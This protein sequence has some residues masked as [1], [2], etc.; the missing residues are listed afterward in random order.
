MLFLVSGSS[1]AGKT[2][3]LN[4]LRGRLSGLAMHDFDE[5]EIPPEVDTAWRQQANE[6]W[7]R[8]GLEYEAEGSDL[9]LAGQTPFGELLATPSA[10]KLQAISACLLDC[11]APTQIQRLA[12]R[13]QDWLTDSG[14]ELQDF[15]NWAAWHRRHAIDPSWMLHV[16]RQP[17]S[18]PDLQWKRWTDWHAGDPRWRVRV[19]DT[20]PLSID[21]VGDEL[22]AWIEEERALFHR[23]AHPL[24]DWA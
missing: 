15:L 14:G 24:T 12:P 8:R 3:A 6:V 22:A 2:T 21:G 18:P 7:V 20:S 19:I 5:I 1:G 10:P 13:G 9:L 4:T 23:G 11:D 17:S 16:I